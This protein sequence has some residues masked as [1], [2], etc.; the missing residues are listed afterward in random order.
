MNLTPDQA[1]TQTATVILI[2]TRTEVHYKV[3]WWEWLGKGKSLITI[4][5][6]IFIRYG[7][8]NIVDAKRKVYQSKISDI[9]GGGGTV[10]LEAIS[11][12]QAL[13]AFLAPL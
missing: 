10:G 1:V 12:S 9:S 6:N 3:T 11:F 13:T 5:K 7:F 2:A 4:S 8:F